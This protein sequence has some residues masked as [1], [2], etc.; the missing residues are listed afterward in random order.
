MKPSLLKWDIDLEALQNSIELNEKTLRINF[1]GIIY[2]PVE[3]K[4]VLDFNKNPRL[5]IEITGYNLTDAYYLGI[6]SFELSTSAIDKMV[7]FEKTFEF[8][9]ILFESEHLNTINIELSVACKFDGEM[10]LGAERDAGTF[11][12]T[13]FPL[14]LFEGDEN[15]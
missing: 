4:S 6:T 2:L 9:K 8:N 13:T 14:S 3:I 12:I 15:E 5:F 10:G 7:S 1:E 11:F